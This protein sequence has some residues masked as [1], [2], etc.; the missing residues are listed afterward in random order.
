MKDFSMGSLISRRPF[1]GKSILAGY[2]SVSPRLLWARADKAVGE[3]AQSA[4]F[5]PQTP[6]LSGVQD[7]GILL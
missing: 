3:V 4:R 2:L 1:L 7:Y 6:V 5:R